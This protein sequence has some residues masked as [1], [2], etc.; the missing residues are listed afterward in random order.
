MPFKNEHA[1][2][3][4]D[5][6]SLDPIR[7]R[8]TEGSGDAKIQGVKIP[9]SISVVWFIIEKDDKEVPVAQSL[10]FPVKK[11]TAKEAKK[12]LKDNDISFILFEKADETEDVFAREL[13]LPIF[14]FNEFNQALSSNILAHLLFYENVFG[15]DPEEDERR[16]AFGLDPLESIIKMYINSPGGQVTDLMAIIDSMDNIETDIETHC[17][18]MAASCAAVLLSNGAKGKRFIGKNANVLLHQVSTVAFGQIEDAEIRINFAKRLNEQILDILSKN[19]GK[20]KKTIR[21]DMDRD[22]WLNA[23][24]A[25]A[26]GIVD[27]ILDD[28]SN[29]IKMFTNFETKGGLN[30]EK[31]TFD[32][33]LEIKSF[34]DEDDNIFTFEGYVSV[35][36]SVDRVGDIVCEGAF[37]RTLK[38][39][40]LLDNPDER[41][42]LWNHDWDLPVGK[43][44][45]KADKNGLSFKGELPKDDDF[46]KGRVI[47]QIKIGSI[48]SMSFGYKTKKA[49][50]KEGNRH[51]TDIDLYEVTISTIPVMAESKIT[52]YKSMF[53][54]DKENG[55]FSIEIDSLKSLKDI[56]NCFKGIG[57]T[58]N[59]I[60]GIMAKMRDAIKQG[61]PVDTSKSYPET[62]RILATLNKINEN[63]NKKED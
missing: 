59:Q 31:K 45:L 8:R 47:P 29:E 61:K 53:K 40:T 43:A 11:W 23:E 26:Y 21:A 63:I 7:V 51:L 27:K 49:H 5:P 39:L 25:L 2:R 57:F 32:A 15:N 41:S 46:V 56:N 9:K 28:D 19:T 33:N 55:C 34:D 52:S 24:E 35:F 12:W 4:K 3:L 48:K 16:K 14:V 22:L 50:H 37:D 42:I 13:S 54:K 30:L 17:L 44:Y 38:E 18:G 1:A 62:S 6:D 60:E 36:N 10:R 58:N 20:D